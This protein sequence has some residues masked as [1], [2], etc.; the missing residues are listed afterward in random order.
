MWLTDW[1]SW[2][3][4]HIYRAIL[5]AAVLEGMGLPI[6]S[7]V[8]FLPGV[9]LVRQG[10]ASYLGMVL[11]ASLG[12][13]AGGL[14]GFSLAYMGGTALFQ[15]VSRFLGIRSNA[16]RKVEGFFARYGQAAVFVSRFVGVVRAATIYAA[17][18]ARMSPLRFALY[19]TVASV[20]WNAG[21]LFVIH[22]FHH[23]AL[24]LLHGR[25]P[26]DLLLSLVALAAALVLGKYLV[27]WF[28]RRNPTAP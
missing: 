15:T 16:M 17:G 20:L 18:A 11:V 1:S 12:N 24:R 27:G 19:L 10:E 5:V 26:G 6:P 22:R 4:D 28:R 13:V 7:E 23:E 8:L 25:G 21:W 3:G 14:I 9:A 2:F